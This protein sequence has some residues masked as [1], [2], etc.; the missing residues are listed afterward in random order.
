MPIINDLFGRLVHYNIEPD[1]VEAPQEANQLNAEQ[2]QLNA[3]VNQ[4]IDNMGAVANPLPQW[5]NRPWGAAPGEFVLF[6]GDNPL[7]VNPWQNTA[8][9]P[10][11]YGGIGAQIQ[12]NN[13]PWQVAMYPPQRFISELSN[14]TIEKIAQRLL[15]LIEER[16]AE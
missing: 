14:E 12:Y 8:P 3:Q 4:A 11:M 1:V 6:E 13:E 2:A 7:G 5:D 15:I 16:E 10:P 9:A